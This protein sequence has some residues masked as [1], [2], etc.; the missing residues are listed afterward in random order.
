[1]TD[2]F[3]NLGDAIASRGDLNIDQ[4]KLADQIAKYKDMVPSAEDQDLLRENMAKFNNLAQENLNTE[5]LTINQMQIAKDYRANALASMFATDLN[6]IESGLTIIT[7]D[8]ISEAGVISSNQDL[9]IVASN[10]V[11]LTNTALSSGGETNISALG[12]VTSEVIIGSDQDLNIVASNDV[13]LTNTALSSGGET[14][15]SAL[16][17]V[18]IV[19]DLATY[20]TSNFEENNNIT[21][22]S[23]IGLSSISTTALSDITD[24]VDN[25]IT[26]L[27]FDS[28]S[29][30]NISS[31]GDLTIA[32][33]YLNTGGSIYLT[34]TGDINNSNQEVN[35]ADDIVMSG[36]NIY[37]RHI[38]G[39]NPT[40]ITSGDTTYL[41]ATGD[42]LNEL[43]EISSS[44]LT[45]VNAG[46]S[47]TNHGGS[48][49]AGDILYLEA[50]ADITNKAYITSTIDG[51]T[52]TND[53]ARS[54]NAD[55]IRQNLEAK[56]PF[57]Q[58]VIWS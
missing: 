14:N 8:I 52:A 19:K 45:Y 11:S 10:D 57:H 9:N 15:I 55:N 26:D 13:S 40:I 23:L 39:G 50:G 49:L 22:S 2:F 33:D 18:A 16:G 37:N 56:A 3:D 58:M 41:T 21:T 5:F 34:A 42:I 46:G 6:F 35:A 27:T 12:D 31:A 43:A 17:D 20:T 25:R 38:S 4:E 48:I 32:T 36:A 30:I 54:S 28:A 51:A 44:G 1:M 53:A 29:D 47:I 24:E 7:D